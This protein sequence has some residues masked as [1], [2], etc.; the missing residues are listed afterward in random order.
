LSILR[1]AGPCRCMRLNS[2]VRPARMLAKSIACLA[3]G[4][5]M[6]SPAGLLHHRKVRAT[7]GQFV[8]G[9]SRRRATP[10]GQFVVP[11]QA[12]E[13]RRH[14]EATLSLGRHSLTGRK[15]RA[16]SNCW[17]SRGQP[18]QQ[19]W[20]FIMSPAQ[21]NFTHHQRGPNRSVEATHNGIGPRG[22][23][24][25]HAPRGPMPSRAPHLQR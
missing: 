11:A 10:H 12:P 20:H 1:L 16:L 14:V 15:R 2:N 7:C 18:G 19:C 4:A 5:S 21:P 8:V 6:R 13:G 3:N 17:C 23:L 22:S 24:V 25:H 9:A